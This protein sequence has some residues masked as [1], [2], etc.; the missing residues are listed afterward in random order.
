MYIANRIYPELLPASSYLA[1]RVNVAN[2]LDW[3]VAT[4]SLREYIN[5]DHETHKMIIR[6]TS[7]D[8]VGCSDASYACH[9]DG[10]SR[11]WCFLNLHQL[12]AD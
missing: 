2:T 5:H 7:L 4:I 12:Q 1:S 11:T 9:D 3:E 6:P 8:A 10:K